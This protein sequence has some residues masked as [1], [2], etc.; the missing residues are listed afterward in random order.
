[1]KSQAT[2][3]KMASSK[4]AQKTAYKTLKQFFY[5]SNSFRVIFVLYVKIGP[6]L[7]AIK[8]GFELKNGV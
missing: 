4:R 8:T 2:I 5:S 3:T 6:K 1:M 7:C